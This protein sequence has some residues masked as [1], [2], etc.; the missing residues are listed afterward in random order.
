[1]GD[2]SVIDQTTGEIRR[3]EHGK[4]Y[5]VEADESKR[6]IMGPHFFYGP[7]RLLPGKPK[8]Y[9]LIGKRKY[10][11][12]LLFRPNEDETVTIIDELGLEDY[13]FGVLPQEMSPKW[14]LEALKAQAVVARTF[15]LNNLGKFSS[16]GFDLSDDFFSQIYSGVTLESDSVKRAVEETA[17]EVLFWRGKR[18]PA[19]FHSCCGGHTTDPAG[20]WGP[21]TKIR[22]SPP[23]PLRGVRDRYCK[24]S[25]HYRWSAYFRKDDLLRMLQRQ[26]R[27]VATL[28][29]MRGGTRSPSG[30]LSDVRFLVDG[31]W[32]R[33]SANKLRLWL[34][35]G[36]LKSSRIQRIV[37]RKRGFEIFGR[38]YGHGVG[39]CQW[40]TRVQAELGRD[41]RKILSFYFPGSKIVRFNLVL[42]TVL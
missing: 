40:G 13:L 20:V 11:G 31:S 24:V 42:L 32:I 36:E 2:F 8:E 14:P 34:G 35:P 19:Y 37:R 10:R 9:V 27:S 5:K 26:G 18:L 23:R 21:R 7:T 3:L 29:R 28:T 4:E 30:A 39:L 12:N 38:G 22:S 6:L 17:K 15:A 41:Y 16:S 25:P 1:M 33:V